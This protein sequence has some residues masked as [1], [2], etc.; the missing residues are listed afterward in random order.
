MQDTDDTT[1]TSLEDCRAFIAE[2]RLAEL[3]AWNA[4]HS[5]QAKKYAALYDTLLDLWPLIAMQER[6]TT[7]SAPSLG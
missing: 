6:I 5:G 3:N 2:A 1:P 4:D 7:S